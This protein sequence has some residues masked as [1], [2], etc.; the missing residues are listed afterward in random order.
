MVGYR[1]YGSRDVPLHER[2]IQDGDGNPIKGQYAAVLD[3]DTWDKVVELL[4]G[5]GRPMGHAH[6]GK[7][8]ELLSGLMRCSL[9]GG[10]LTVNARGQDRFDYSCK[11]AGCGK[12]CGS[13]NAID[14]LVT[15]LVFACLEEQHVEVEAQVWSKAEELKALGESKASLLAQFKENPDMGSYIWPEVRKKEAAIAELTRERAAYA[16]TQAKPK[17]GDVVAAWPTLAVEQRRAICAEMFEALILRPA[18][19]KSR[20]FDPSRL[21]V[22]HHQE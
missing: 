8:K 22:V 20:R 7:L 16:R 1:V 10:K 12:V 15:A 11:N 13:G 18:T 14:E 4:T 5:P 3:V 6:I 17:D 2:Y 21:L 19:R 9:C